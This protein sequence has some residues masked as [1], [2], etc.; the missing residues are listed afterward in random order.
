M[1]RFHHIVKAFIFFGF[2]AYILVLDKKGDLQLYIAPRMELYVKLAALGL[3]IVA[4][5]HCYHFLIRKQAEVHCDCGH[6]HASPSSFKSLIIYAIFFMPILLGFLTPD[7]I[8]GSQM[9]EQKGVNFSSAS[10]L[11]TVEPSSESQIVE[12]EDVLSEVERTED[13]LNGVEI[14]IDTSN[15]NSET[16]AQEL[17]ENQSSE[18]VTELPEEDLD[19]LFASETFTEIYANYGKEIYTHDII[20]VQEDIYLETLTTLDL[21]LD[22]FIGKQIEISGFIFRAD[23][24][25]ENEFAVGRFAVQCCS[26]DA[27][28]YGVFLEYEDAKS[29]V[30]DEWV[31]IMGTIDRTTFNDFDIIKV[32][33]KEIKRIE[34]P[35]EPYVYTN[36]DFG[37]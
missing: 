29:W 26:A 19:T 9:A 11:K 30:D 6:N 32:N 4:L 14:I 7:T 15:S 23:G 12:P 3:F 20:R 28:P 36:Y 16:E 17:S 13:M 8:L 35:A 5:Y 22:A 37:L 21:F 24:M 1:S 25:K 34:A 33:I 10:S 27:S 2:F 31:T 18:I